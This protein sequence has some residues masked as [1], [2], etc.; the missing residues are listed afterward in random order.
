MLMAADCPIVAA[1][2]MKALTYA[3][4]KSPAQVLTLGCLGKDQFTNNFNRIRGCT[5]T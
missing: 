3:L 2:A 5:R 1:S 4:T